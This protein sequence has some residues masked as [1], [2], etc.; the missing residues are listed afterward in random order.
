MI[1]LI[2]T[3]T[4][5][6]AIG[7][8]DGARL[9]I[10]TIKSSP[11]NNRKLIGII[12]KFIEKESGMTDVSPSGKDNRLASVTPKHNID[13][14]GIV[15][16]PGTFTGVRTGVT[17][18]NALGYALRAPIYSLDTLSAQVPVILTNVV[19]LVSASNNEVYFARFKNGKM[20]AC[21]DQNGRGKIELVDTMNL[22]NRLDDSDL[23]M[24]DLGEKHCGITGSN[25]LKK[26]NS[27]DRIKILL[28]MIL[29]NKIRPAKQVLPLYIK[30]P[31]ITRPKK[32]LS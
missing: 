30:K 2:D 12:K 32:K 9:N 8:W 20:Q 22:P 28:Q 15:N 14:I 3:T 23:V 1:F 11:N 31:N 18:V 5:P 21:L 29:N 17:I 16:G 19:S 13:A 7:L 10:K 25:E 26:V 24:G 27:Q 4:N 6:S